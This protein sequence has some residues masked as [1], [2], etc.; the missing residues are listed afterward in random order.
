MRSW[1]AKFGMFFPRIYFGF[2]FGAQWVP[3][4]PPGEAGGHND[5]GMIYLALIAG[6]DV[7]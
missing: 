7:G 1:Y 6:A 4:P 2:S 5:F 3:L